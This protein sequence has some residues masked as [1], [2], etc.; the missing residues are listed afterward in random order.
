MF[1]V[2]FFIVVLA[3]SYTPLFPVIFREAMKYHGITSPQHPKP[4][5]N[6]LFFSYF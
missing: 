3:K 2:I 5:R 6:N 4:S 1:R